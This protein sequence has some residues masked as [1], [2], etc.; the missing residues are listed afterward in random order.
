M[1]HLFMYY[2]LKNNTQKINN[3]ISS[4][5]YKCRTRYCMARISQQYVVKNKSEAEKNK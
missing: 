3:P 5:I 2:V 1:L 4:Y